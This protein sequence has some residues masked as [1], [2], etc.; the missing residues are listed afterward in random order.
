MKNLIMKD[1]GF[2][3]LLGVILSIS[4]GYIFAGQIIT[5]MAVLL[6]T[7][8]VTIGGFYGFRF[9]TN[10]WVHRFQKQKMHG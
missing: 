10:Q 1:D 6:L 5:G 4:I 8:I 7:G 3:L 2:I 9:L